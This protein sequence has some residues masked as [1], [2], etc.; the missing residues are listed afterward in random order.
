MIA[1][2]KRELHQPRLKLFIDRHMLCNM[3][4]AVERNWEDMSGAALWMMSYI[5]LLRLPSEALPAC[6]GSPDNA[7]LADK[8]TLVWR[9]GDVIC[10]RL[11]RRKNMPHGSGTLRRECTCRG[12][13]HTC[14]VHSLWERFWLHKDEGEQPWARLN[15]SR[16]TS[17]MRGL[18]KRMRVPNAEQYGTHDFRRGH[19]DDMRKLGCTLP[20]ILKAGQWRSASF[21]SYIDEAG[22]DRV[23]TSVSALAS[24]MLSLLAGPGHRGGHAERGGVD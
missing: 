3:V 24:I 18:L 17:K 2:K 12:S 11:L 1:I 9:E 13:V 22:L 8:Q 16:A 7:Q 21:M 10:L 20:E 4:L 6:K 15:P 23:C 19:A 5:F 14:A